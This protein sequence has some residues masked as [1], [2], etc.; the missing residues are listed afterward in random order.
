MHMH[1]HRATSVQ[2]REAY[3]KLKA[4]RPGMSKKDMKEESGL[5][6]STLDRIEDGEWMSATVAKVFLDMVAKHSSPESAPLTPD[7]EA[8]Q[9]QYRWMERQNNKA[10]FKHFVDSIEPL[11]EQ[12]QALRAAEHDSIEDALRAIGVLWV[13]AWIA[14]DRAFYLREGHSHQQHALSHWNAAVDRLTPLA[15]TAVC[16]APLLDKLRLGRFVTYFDGQP[17]ATRSTDPEVGQWIKGNDMIAVCRAL[18]LRDPYAWSPIRN[19]LVMASILKLADA[20]DAFYRMLVAADRHFADWTYQPTESTPS[21]STDPDLD[22]FRSH[23]RPLTKPTPQLPQ[24]D[25]L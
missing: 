22:F 6:L 25:Q 21:V 18:G 17:R 2:L 24:G 3:F 14:H 11:L 16:Y 1:M 4:M 12:H 8:L 7:I 5:P 23:V 13:L 15:A 19:G 9:R 10:L 20:C